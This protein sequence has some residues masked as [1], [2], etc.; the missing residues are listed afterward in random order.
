VSGPE[1]EYKSEHFFSDSDSDQA[2][3][4]GFFR[5]RNHNTGCQGLCYKVVCT[6]VQNVPSELVAAAGVDDRWPVS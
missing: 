6:I 3:I 4:F 1:S 5:I 2:K